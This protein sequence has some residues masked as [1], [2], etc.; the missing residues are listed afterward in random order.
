MRKTFYTA[1]GLWLLCTLLLIPAEGSG[2][3]PFGP[4]YRDAGACIVDH[5]EVC[6][7]RTIYVAGEPVRFRADYFN[8]GLPGD[9][10]WSSVVY[11][12]LIAPDGS[13]VVVSKWAMHDGFASGSLA[14]PGEVLT[15]HYLLRCYTR[16]MRNRGPGTYSHTPLTIINPFSRQVADTG[17]ARGQGSD[18]LP[19]PVEEESPGTILCSAEKTEY[20]PGEWVRIALQAPDGSPPEGFG[21]SLTVAPEGSVEPLEDRILDGSLPAASDSFQLQYLPDLGEAFTLSGMMVTGEGRP[22]ADGA[23]SFSLLGPEPD[24]ITANTGP[25]GRF[26]VQIPL[27]KSGQAFLVTPHPGEDDSLAVRID[28]DMDG[29]RSPVMAGGFRMTAAEEAVATRLAVRWQIME[30]YREQDTS[31]AAKEVPLDRT[32]PFY[33]SDVERIELKEYVNLPTLEEIFINLVHGVN[34]VRRR[35]RIS[36]SIEGDNSSLGFYRPLVLV[37]F[38]PV[39]D[40]TTLLAQDPREFERIEVIR[41][42]YVKGGMAFGGVIS[43]FTGNG[44]MAGLDLPEGSYFFDVTPLRDSEGGIVTGE[45][46]A[47]VSEDR[48]PDLRNT[49]MWEPDLQFSPGS[50]KEMIIRAPDGPGAYV[51]RVRGALSPGKVLVGETRFEVRGSGPSSGM[52]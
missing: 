11:V 32:L 10:P 2:Q 51:V 48:V 1:A 35:G 13:P 6:T 14:I 8:E 18:H 17:G 33:G 39:F 29:R 34:V 12:E 15:G 40:H 47:P 24:L 31:V 42:V 16:W 3:T 5:L 9:L 30:S 7:D 20:L 46:S 26:A 25:Q 52:P 23:L 38:V 19:E 41:E 45:L 27:R 49:V 50:R 4:E 37:D 43:L 28:Q 44:D 22:V 21:A 36:F